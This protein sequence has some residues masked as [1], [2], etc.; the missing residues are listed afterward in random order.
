MILRLL[1]K[2]G[3]NTEVFLHNHLDKLSKDCNFNREIFGGKVFTSIP[4]N[5]NNYSLI[6]DGLY[7]TGLSRKLDNNIL[8]LIKSINN[9]GTPVYAIDVPSGIN[10]DSSLIYG[11]T[12]QCQKT[13][14]FFLTK[15]NVITCFQAKDIV[16]K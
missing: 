4:S 15:R 6:I 8:K 2:K 10:T 9:S 12:F 7:G 14:T 3:V 16:V 11:D 13:I 1:L 5:F